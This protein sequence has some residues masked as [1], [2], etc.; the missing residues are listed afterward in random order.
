MSERDPS[1]TD[2]GK[3]AAAASNAKAPKPIVVNLYKFKQ[4]VVGYLIQ[5][6]PRLY[7]FEIATRKAEPLTAETLDVASPSWSHDGNS[8]AFL[9]KEGKDSERYNTW[10]V[11]VMHARVGAALRQLP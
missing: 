5:K 3:H 11:Y 2:E 9:G 10:N 6:T 4:D 8:I 1:V 7:L